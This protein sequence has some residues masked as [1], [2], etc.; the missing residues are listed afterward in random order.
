MKGRFYAPASNRQ[1]LNKITFYSS[2]GKKELF[3]VR[4][5]RIYYNQTGRLFEIEGVQIYKDEQ[6]YYEYYFG[7]V[8]RQDLMEQIK[9][10]E[11]KKIVDIY[12]KE[13]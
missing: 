10:I 6:G 11:Q 4:E 5:F 12:E 1:H 9:I 3:N 13:Y 2:K 7:T 8:F